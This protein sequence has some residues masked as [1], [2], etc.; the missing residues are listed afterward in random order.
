MFAIIWRPTRIASGGWTEDVTRE[1]ENPTFEKWECVVF[2][3]YPRS[4]R[5]GKVRH[6]P[7]R[8]F[9]STCSVQWSR[10]ACLRPLIGEG[11]FRTLLQ[12]W[13]FPQRTP[14]TWAPLSLSA[15][16]AEKNLPFVFSKVHLSL[17]HLHLDIV[18]PKFN[19]KSE[20]FHSFFQLKLVTY[21]VK[22]KQP[23]WG[24]L[25]LFWVW[26]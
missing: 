11:C 21:T 3:A 23:F 12:H 1:V 19:W 10:F 24:M 13:V 5:M 17:Q 15:A 22:T 4:R 9:V 8:G 25:H 14:R 16:A 7:R 2:K 6:R 20:S 26:N 18:W